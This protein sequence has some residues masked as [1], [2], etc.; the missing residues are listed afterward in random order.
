MLENASNLQLCAN[1]ERSRPLTRREAVHSRPQIP[2]KSV[3][4]LLFQRTKSISLLWNSGSKHNSPFCQ[5]KASVHK[6]K[7]TPF[8]L[9]RAS[10]DLPTVNIVICLWKL[11]FLVLQNVHR[12][13]LKFILAH[14]LQQLGC[15]THPYMKVCVPSSMA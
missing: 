1:E 3:F 10:I 4:L 5:K 12:N 14:F 7:E 15:Q 13:P 6:S 11:T 9:T 8:H 2:F